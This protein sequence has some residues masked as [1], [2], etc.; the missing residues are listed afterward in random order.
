MRFWLHEP[1]D[2]LGRHVLRHFDDLRIVRNADRDPATPSM[3]R[4]LTA[5]APQ[6]KADHIP[7]RLA[8]EC[9]RAIL[10]GGP[11]PAPLLAAAVMRCRAEQGRKDPRSGKPLQ[12]VSYERAALLKACLN[13]EHRR[14]HGLPADFHFIGEKLDVN[15]TDPAYRLG[16]LF[17]VLELAQSRAQPASTRRSA[18][19]TTAPPPA[20][21]LR[22]SPR[23]C[24]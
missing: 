13:R 22:C 24:G 16:R 7:P 10:E 3:L 8:G 17:A 6:G 21:P 11:Y 9:M 19:A 1:F 23:C 20:R 15:Q 4:L 18:I 2:R 12:N 5:I 14:R